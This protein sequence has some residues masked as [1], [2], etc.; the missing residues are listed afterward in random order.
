MHTLLVIGDGGSL[1]RDARALLAAAGIEA[2]EAP[3]GDPPRIEARADLLLVARAVPAAQ[4]LAIAREAR[5]SPLL[6]ETPVIVA[7]ERREAAAVLPGQ[8]VD[9]I[10]CRP[11]DAGELLARAR[12][13]L[14][15]SRRVAGEGVVSAG[16]LRIDTRRYEVTL[17]GRRVDLTLKEY[18]LLLFLAQ[19]P[20]R[21]FTR[22]VLLDRI[23]GHAYFG[24]TRTVDVHV[25]RL[26]MKFEREGRDFV[27]T[28]RGVGYRFDE[29]APP[30]AGRRGRGRGGGTGTGTCTGTGRETRGR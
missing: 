14:Y 12:F 7:V 6:E 1:D 23:W 5:R 11:V 18:E 26:R 8:G 21:V 17:G 2:R 22:E 19:H 25:R 24:G 15:R 27:D 16:E 28:V 4:A 30:L 20:G 9:D 13:L 10:L 29:E 3:P